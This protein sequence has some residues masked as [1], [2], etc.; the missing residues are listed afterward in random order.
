MDELLRKLLDELDSIGQSN[1]EIYDSECRDKI[2]DPI[3][4]RFLRP[5]PQYYV[6]DDFG[7]RTEDANLRA[8]AALIAYTDDARKTAGDL[9]L[10]TFHA[11][12]EAFQNGDVAS[13]VENNYFDDFFGWID[14]DRFDDSGKSIQRDG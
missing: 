13:T 4:Y 11:R 14:P 5:D 7:L 9:G 6:P 12:L 3:L 10:N 2:G 1:E 8:K